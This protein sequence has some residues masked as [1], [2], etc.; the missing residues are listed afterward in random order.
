M[1]NN[2]KNF[3]IPSENVGK[4]P[5]NNA[6]KSTSDKTLT[7]DNPDVSD[8]LLDGKRKLAFFKNMKQSDVKKND[9]K[10]KIIGY[11]IIPATKLI[12]KR[13]YRKVK[14]LY[15]KETKTSRIYNKIEKVVKNFY[16]RIADSTDQ[17]KLS[18]MYHDNEIFGNFKYLAEQQKEK[19]PEMYYLLD[20]FLIDVINR[21]Q[22]D[23]HCR[24]NQQNFIKKMINKV[25]RV[26]RNNKNINDSSKLFKFT[27]NSKILSN[28]WF[29]VSFNNFQK[30]KK[31]NQR[32]NQVQKH[33]RNIFTIAKYYDWPN[34]EYMKEDPI[35]EENID[36]KH[37]ILSVYALKDGD[38][39]IRQNIG[40]VNMSPN[41]CFIDH[42][43]ESI[44]YESNDEYSENEQ[45]IM[46]SSMNADYYEDNNM[47]I[48]NDN[49]YYDE[50]DDDNYGE[51]SFLPHQTN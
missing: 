30:K 21:I 5:P 23:N 22:K 29:Q 48:S 17:D 28:L 27:K 42:E 20:T 13:I 49:S 9:T 1:N 41:D 19:N 51:E 6:L 50:R 43:I 37:E 47:N 25:M 45:T 33:S 2:S 39:S 31:N 4:Q 38:F 26:V 35:T 12:L 36:H 46:Q 8:K 44:S 15:K 11:S 14:G 18:R 7:S 40:E 24:V 34:S 32:R 3:F 10:R 16:Y